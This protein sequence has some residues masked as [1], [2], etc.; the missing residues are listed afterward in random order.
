MTELHTATA[1]PYRPAVSAEGSGPGDDL[2]RLRAAAEGLEA[3]FLSVMLQSAGFGAPREAFGGG[4][5]EAQFA[6]FLADAHAEAMVGRGGIGLAEAIF[7]SL[8][9]R[10]HG[11]V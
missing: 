10:T 5:G 6:S 4:I 11:R 3:N 9:A 7:E 8:K 2:R 1:R